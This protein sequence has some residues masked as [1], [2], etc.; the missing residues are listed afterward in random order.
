MSFDMEK[1]FLSLKTCVTN[2]C[3]GIISSTLSK[4]MNYIANVMMTAREM[5]CVCEICS[6]ISLADKTAWKS[7]QKKLKAEVRT[8]LFQ[9]CDIIIIAYNFP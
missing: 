2:E 4:F 6:Y 7:V 1:L 9:L 3:I 8:I 5:W